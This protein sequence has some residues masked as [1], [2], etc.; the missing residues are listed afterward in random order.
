MTSHVLPVLAVLSL[1]VPLTGCI[2][3]G[4]AGI[5]G[6]IPLDLR[7]GATLVAHLAPDGRQGLLVEGRQPLSSGAL[8]MA[9]LPSATGARG[10]DVIEIEAETGQ[11]LPTLETHGRAA[12]FARAKVGGM[13][14][15]L[16][17]VAGPD[18]ADP[19]GLNE[20]R[21][22]LIRALRLR[23]DQGPPT[24]EQIASETTRRRYCSPAD[25]LAVTY[26]IALPDDRGVSDRCRPTA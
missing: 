2:A 12:V 16:L 26:R 14:A 8:L 7:E 13:P 9:M 1:L 23:I 6:V 18:A 24:F 3:R 10:W 5:T 22:M 21:R 11:H 19:A 20:P 15:T 4:S 25:A 17:L